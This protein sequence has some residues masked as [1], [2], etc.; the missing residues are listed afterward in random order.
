MAINKFLKEL[1][2]NQYFESYKQTR[3]ISAELLKRFGA[4][5]A[6]LTVALKR[7]VFLRSTEKG[8][9][10]KSRPDHASTHR[11]GPDFFETFKIHSSIVKVSKKLFEQEDYAE[12]IRSAYIEIN[13]L[14][15]AKSGRHDLDGKGLM[16]T[17]FSPTAP[18]LKFNVLSTRS[19]RDEQEG[20][21]HL[22]AGAMHGIRNPKAHEN[23]VQKDPV[24]TME[25]LM[26]A[27]YLCKKLDETK[28]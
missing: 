2:K 13:S 19:E 4:T 3:E 26:F 25:L 15:K 22:F 14:V 17:A 8:W 9:I 27:S 6:N 18:V 1:W 5:H 7:T 28:K 12:A 23:I 24:R 10:Q 21:M 16:L 11:D 20:L